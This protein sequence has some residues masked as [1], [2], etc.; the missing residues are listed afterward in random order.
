[1]KVE[2][3]DGAQALGR[4]SRSATQRFYSLR[5][6]CGRAPRKRRR[7]KVD[8][9]RSGSSS[10]TYPRLSPCLSASVVNILINGREAPPPFLFAAQVPGQFLCQPSASGTLRVRKYESVPSASVS[11]DLAQSCAAPF[12]A[13]PARRSFAT[14][15]GLEWQAGFGHRARL[16]TA[17]V[18]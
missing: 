3:K 13:R 5:D 15:G 17:R 12:F 4:P 7:M 18:T 1:M 10:S 2:L 6:L 11:S 14:V 8:K 16:A 9:A